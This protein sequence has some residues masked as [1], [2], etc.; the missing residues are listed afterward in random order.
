VGDSKEDRTTS[1]VLISTT[2]VSPETST[3]T[4]ERNSLEENREEEETADG[5][6]R[7][8]ETQTNEGGGSAGER[9]EISEGMK[10]PADFKPLE[11]VAHGQ[12]K[13]PART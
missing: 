10:E 8:R 1:M 7:T 6:G 11:T 4:R 3:E 13:R 12:M 9:Q 5:E 2:T